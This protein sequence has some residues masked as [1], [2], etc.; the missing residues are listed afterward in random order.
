MILIVYKT[1]TLSVVGE[2]LTSLAPFLLL[3]VHCCTNSCLKK[4]NKTKRPQKYELINNFVFQI[5]FLNGKRIQLNNST[6][7]ETQRKKSY[8]IH[9]QATIQKTTFRQ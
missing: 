5:K 8:T 9:S 7:I 1:Y 4:T 6:G 3:H 2:P